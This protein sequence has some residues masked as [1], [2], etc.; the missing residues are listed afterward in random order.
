MVEFFV[1]MRTEF[2]I[3]IISRLRGQHIQDKVSS[4]WKLEQQALPV[5]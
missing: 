4:V 2:G 3:E 1:S 5:I